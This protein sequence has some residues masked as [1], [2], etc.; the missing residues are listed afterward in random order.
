MEVVEIWWNLEKTR[1]ATQIM[2]FLPH[3]IGAENK[4]W[5]QTVEYLLILQSHW[6]KF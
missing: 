1:D 4:N 6:L 5:S 3:S 2:I